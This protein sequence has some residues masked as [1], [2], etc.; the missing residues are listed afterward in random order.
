MVAKR[1]N[2]AL[3]DGDSFSFLADRALRTTG[4]DGGWLIFFVRERFG[5]EREVQ[6]FPAQMVMGYWAQKS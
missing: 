4:S 1:F 3:T 5:G 6:R 2:V